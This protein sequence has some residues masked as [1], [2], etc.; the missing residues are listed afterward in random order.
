MGDRE[1]GPGSAMSDL[2]PSLKPLKVEKPKR[3]AKK[4]WHPPGSVP[5]S[6]YERKQ[7]EAAFKKSR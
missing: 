5:Q 6:T 1:T 2:Y 4:V 3:D 7:F